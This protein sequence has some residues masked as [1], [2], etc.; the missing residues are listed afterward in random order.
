MKK[1][2]NE[3]EIWEKVLLSAGNEKCDWIDK[4]YLKPVLEAI[5]K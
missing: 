4:K 1:D 3:L 2:P 5:D